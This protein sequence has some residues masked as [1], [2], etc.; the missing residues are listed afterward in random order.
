M[1]SEQNTSE[2]LSKD[3]LIFLEKMLVIAKGTG[4]ETK[5]INFYKILQSNK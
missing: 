4:F 1:E 3:D 5:W 2:K